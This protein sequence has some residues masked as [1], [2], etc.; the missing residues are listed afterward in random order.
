M[1]ALEAPM[2]SFKAPQVS[3][4]RQLELEQYAWRNRR[5]LTDSEARLWEA[6][7]GRKLGVQFRRQVPLGERYVVDFAASAARLVVEV[8]GGCHARRRCADERRDRELGRLGWR[9][10]R[11]PAALVM[12]D[13]PAAMQR[14]IDALKETK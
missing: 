14:A 9:V 11:L 7:R 5:S 10:L 3:L 1:P 6:L 2:S 13:L 12:R 4:R 8:D